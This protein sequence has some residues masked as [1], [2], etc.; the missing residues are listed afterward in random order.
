MPRRKRRKAPSITGS[1][2]T[3]ASSAS[4][5]SRRIP[6]SPQLHPSIAQR[7]QSEPGLPHLR[8]NRTEKTVHH[9]GTTSSRPSPLSGE[10]VEKTKVRPRVADLNSPSPPILGERDG[11]RGTLSRCRR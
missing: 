4:P 5:L 6:K 9:R 3:S 8:K 2:T 11:V 10:G 1:S 7:L